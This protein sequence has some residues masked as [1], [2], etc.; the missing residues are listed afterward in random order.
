MCWALKNTNM[1]IV[2]AGSSRHWPSYRE[3]CKE[4]SGDRLVVIDHLDQALLASAFA[5]A[6]VHTLTSWM[7]T[8]GLVSLEAALTG[9][10]VVGSTFGHELEYLKNDAWLADPADPKSIREAIEKAWDEGSTGEKCIKLKNRIIKEYNWE[11]TANKTL[12]IYKEVVG[13]G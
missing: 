6:R 3:L 7:D 1:P 11:N 9:T 12:D 13:K 10:P 5:A 2:L 4:I 8:C